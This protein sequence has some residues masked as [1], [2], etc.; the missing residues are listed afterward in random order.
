M[1][2]STVLNGATI[3][4]LISYCVE[5]EK[6]IERIDERPFSTKYGDWTLVSF[7]DSI[8][9]QV[10]TALVKGNISK[11][12]PVCVR[13]H[14][15]NVFTDILQESTESLHVDDALAYI[16][17]EQSGVFLLIRPHEAS[18]DVKTYGVGAQILSDL[19]V[20]KMRILGSPRKL[21]ALKGF[22]LEV[23]EYITGRKE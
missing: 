6:T 12:M 14:M 18:S 8:H 5:N 2:K 20:G 21:N 9:Q 7:L 11:E 17:N 3:E 22:G 15:E 13:V 1:L 4:D 10:H 23:V 19:G 16:S